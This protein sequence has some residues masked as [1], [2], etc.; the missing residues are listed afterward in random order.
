MVAPASTVGGDVKESSG[1]RQ[2]VQTRDMTPAGLVLA[3]DTVASRI[4]GETAAG[5]GSAVPAARGAVS[6]PR[7]MVRLEAVSKTYPGTTRPAVVELSLE[8]RE[9][10]IFALLGP[11]GC[12]KTTTMRIVAGLESPD[13]GA[14][15]FRDKPIVVVGERVYVPPEKRDVGM[16]FQSYAIWPHMTVEENVAYPLRIRGVDDRQITQ[17]VGEALEL[18]G[19]KHLAARPAPMLSGGQ[20]QRVALA[21]ALVYKPNLLL[22]DEPFSNL[23]AKLREQMCVELKLL[24]TRLKITVLFVTH[25]RTEAL[26]LADRIAIMN[27]GVVQ[28]LGTP[29]ELYETPANPFV[30]DFLGKT[31]I[32]RGTVRQCA[33]PIA[34]VAVR[35]S[36]A[37]IAARARRCSEHRSGEE[38]LVALRPEE[39]SLVTSS[40]DVCQP[41]ATLLPGTVEAGLYIG[42]RMEYRVTVAEQG[43]FLLYAD[44]RTQLDVGQPVFV[45]VPPDSATVWPENP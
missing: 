9:G 25:D 30:R 41:G 18:V 31:V 7:A 19:L 33:G 26:G 44:R 20:Q 10:E 43:S 15:Y 6:A 40:S 22:L 1:E 45:L 8:V 24:Q 16:V 32:F 5:T 3:A 27:H 17:R 28:Q 4:A 13:R 21:R 35:G 2:A 29:R 14:L 23:D 36:D 38:V 11:S 37:V 42:D 39:V 34:S 12:G